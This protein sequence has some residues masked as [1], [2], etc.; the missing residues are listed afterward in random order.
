MPPRCK[1]P[2]KGPIS[3]AYV[4]V[5]TSQASLPVVSCQIA[6]L[7]ISRVRLQTAS[8][9]NWLMLFQAQSHQIKSFAR[10]SMSTFQI[11]SGVLRRWRANL[12]APRPVQTPRLSPPHLQ[13]AG[14]PP[15]RLPRLV[16]LLVLFN[17]PSHSLMAVLLQSLQDVRF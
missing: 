2:V 1:H 11:I 8:Q 13:G 15:L 5:L 10:V 16:A 17:H 4:A 6:I 7:R 14:A 12:A 9:G 3:S